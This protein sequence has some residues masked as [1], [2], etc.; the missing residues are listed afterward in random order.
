MIFLKRLSDSA[1]LLRQYQ[2]QHDTDAGSA[3][4]FQHGT[5]SGVGSLTSKQVSF[6]L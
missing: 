2:V 5:Q 4:K 1:C 6:V 3:S